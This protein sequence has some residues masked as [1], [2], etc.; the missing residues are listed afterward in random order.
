MGSW[1]SAR[2]RRA[3]RAFGPSA[4]RVAIGP[5]SVGTSDKA[6]AVLPLPKSRAHLKIPRGAGR[7]RT[8]KFAASIRSFGYLT[9]EYPFSLAEGGSAGRQS[10]ALA[11]ETKRAR[12]HPALTGVW[13]VL[14][15]RFEPCRGASASDEIFDTQVRKHSPTGRAPVCYTGGVGHRPAHAG[16]SPAASAHGGHAVLA[17][18]RPGTPPRPARGAW[19]FDSPALRSCDGP[20]A[21]EERSQL[22]R[23]LRLVVRLHSGSLDTSAKWRNWQTRAPQ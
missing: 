13:F 19:E 8:P 5:K 20:V 14:S 17:R 16:S 4:I 7:Q 2:I 22:R 6:G 15:V 10:V 3:I 1:R 23:R 21:Q 12:R 18:Q 11:L 9:T